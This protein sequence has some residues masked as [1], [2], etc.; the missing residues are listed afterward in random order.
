M[1]VRDYLMGF[2]NQLQDHTKE[3]EQGKADQNELSQAFKIINNRVA[4]VGEI[5]D[6]YMKRLASTKSRLSVDTITL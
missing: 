4:I 3:V 6:E 2:Y 1:V 5:T